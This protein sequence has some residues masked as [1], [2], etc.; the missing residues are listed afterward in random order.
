MLETW[1]GSLGWEDP[2]E[3]MTT[4]SVFLPEE[5]SWTEE[6]GGL[7]S[8]GLQSIGHK[9]SDFT[10]HSKVKLKILQSKLQQ[11]MNQEL[12]VVQAEL[13]KGRETRDQI[14]NIQ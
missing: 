1:V 10:L 12:L 9:L 14:A 2:L 11:Y 13:R 6:P 4:H 3:G 5:S 7:Q 8:M